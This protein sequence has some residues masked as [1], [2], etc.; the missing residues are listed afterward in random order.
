[1]SEYGYIRAHNKEQ[2]EN[3]LNR[4]EGQVRAVKRMVNEEAYCIDILTQISSF[5]AASERV[6]S[7]VLNDHMDYCL[8]EALERGGGEA[9]EKLEEL[10]AAVERFLRLERI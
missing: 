3:R 4:I 6:A 9:D 7:I 8:R 2:L 10:K 5:V 1:V